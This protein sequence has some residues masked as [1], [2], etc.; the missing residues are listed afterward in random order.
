MNTIL[1][2]I[3]KQLRDIQTEHIWIGSSFAKKLDAI[4]DDMMFQKP[5]AQLHSIAQIIAHLT[6]WRE[7][8]ILKIK[9]GSGSK[10]DDCEENWLS[11]DK[12]KGKGWNQIKK[13]FDQSLSELIQLLEEK[14]DSFLDEQYYDTDFK[15]TYT[16]SF[17][18]NGMLHHD[19]YHLGQIGIIAKHLH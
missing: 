16:Y 12:L 6:L 19:L 4:D 13:E 15:G 17:L 2:Y 3:V 14:E 5:N 1:T 18:I 11:N 7:E 10:T 8:A 9:T